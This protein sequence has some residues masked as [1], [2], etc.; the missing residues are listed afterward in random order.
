V[1]DLVIIIV[2]YNTRADLDR[3]LRSLHAA[4]PVVRHQIVV[5]DNGSTDGSP[6]LV[7]QSWP[8]VRLIEAGGNRGFARA[9]NLAIRAT[10]SDLVLLLNSDT[11]V[12]AGA[13]D[14]LVE[15]LRAH[16]G[17]AAIG[18]RIV[19]G[20]DRAELSFGVATGPWA[21]FQQKVVRRLAGL[22]V[23]VAQ[24]WI[25]R[26]T[27]RP[28]EVAWVTGACLLVR[29]TDAEA[30]GLLDERYFMYCEDMDFCTA[31][32]AHGRQ[33]RFSPAAEIVHYRGRSTA[34]QPATAES[35]YRQSQIVFYEKHHPGW[36]PWLQAY[37]R[38]HRKP[39][40]G[41]ADKRVDG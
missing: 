27:R 23:R 29:R 9:N 20:Q 10:E 3:C 26:Q 37:R 32:R 5:V 30:V 19:D 14:C 13:I 31:L 38:L 15:E 36:L 33:I 35:A 11:V 2:N 4:R 41:S 18:P 16:P 21:D 8:D 12:P 7:R 24:S 22:G 25:E 6:E 34:T 28:R 39:P 1:I 40:G 17:A